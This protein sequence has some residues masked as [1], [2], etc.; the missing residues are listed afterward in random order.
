MFLPG[1]GFCE[2]ASG[3]QVHLERSKGDTLTVEEVGGE[4]KTRA[5][6]R[7]VQIGKDGHPRLSL[8]FIDEPVPERLL[9]PIGEG[10]GPRAG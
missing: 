3:H 7:R 2:P 4:F 9:P 8:L 1:P 5:E 6:V 10:E